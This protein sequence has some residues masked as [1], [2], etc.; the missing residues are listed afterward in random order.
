VICEPHSKATIEATQFVRDQ[1][2]DGEA[3]SRCGH[4]LTAVG[5]GV[6]P[7]GSPISLN[8]QASGPLTDNFVEDN[9]NGAKPRQWYGS[10]ENFAGGA[11]RIFKVIAICE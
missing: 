1:G 7:V 11:G 2:Q 9:Q 3:I 6:T 10:A 5:G 4:G 8:V